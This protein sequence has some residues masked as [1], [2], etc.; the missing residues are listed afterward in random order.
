MALDLTVPADRLAGD[1]S[2]PE[3]SH[4]NPARSLH[5]QTRRPS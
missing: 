3:G 4:R 2:E 5:V 1:K